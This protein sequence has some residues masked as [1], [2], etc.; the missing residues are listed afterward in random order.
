MLLALG[1]SSMAWGQE[2]VVRVVP[3]MDVATL[4][5][6][7]P[8]VQLPL[9]VAP[10]EAKATGLADVIRAKF[11]LAVEFRELGAGWRELLFRGDRYFTKGEATFVNAAEYLIA[12]KY[13][14]AGEAG[15][16]DAKDFIA[17]ETRGTRSF[18]PDDRFALTL[19]SMQSV[20][21]Y[22]IEGQTNLRSF[23][24][25]RLQTAFEPPLSSPAYRQNL[26]LVYL[27]KM[28]EAVGAY[29]STYLNVLPPMETAFA[30]RQA[31]SAFAPNDAIFF[32]PGTQQPF[33]ANPLFSE[34]KREHLRR[35]G[36]LVLFYEATPATDGMRAVLLLNGTVKRVD[37]KA[38]TRLAEASQIP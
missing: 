34:K 12:Y 4:Q 13:D 3:P 21:P 32:V 30:A 23:N 35:A 9:R 7:V 17:R 15:S 1:V 31:L 33:K 27:R 16:R 38:W 20:L 26:T 37:A 10:A 28:H 36:K 8:V 22:L 25:A 19:L 11:P 24:P 6:A 14:G 2:D 29:A 5:S 18:L